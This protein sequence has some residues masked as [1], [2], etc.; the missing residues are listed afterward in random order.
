MHLT[1]KRKRIHCTS[2]KGKRKK[3]K[4]SSGDNKFCILCLILFICFFFFC[5]SVLFSHTNLFFH[6]Y[7]DALKIIWHALCTCPLL[8]RL[9][10]IISTDSVPSMY[11]REY[12]ILYTHIYMYVYTLYQMVSIPFSYLDCVFVVRHF[13]AFYTYLLRDIS[14]LKCRF[15]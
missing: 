1:I 9:C 5:Y 12:F 4:K 8:M 3:T 14:Q 13:Y 2:I 10:A 15:V 11:A 7:I 6:I